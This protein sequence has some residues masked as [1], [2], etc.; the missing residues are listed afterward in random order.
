MS[1]LIVTTV[2]ASGTTLTLND[3][4]TVNG[5]LTATDVNTSSDVALKQDIVTIPDAASIISAMRGVN[6]G[7]KNGGRK[8]IGV[9]AQEVEEILPEIVATDENG[10][11]AVNYAALTGVLI[12][13]VKDLQAQVAKLSK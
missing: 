9:V 3:N 1:T 2:Q 4:T 5:T 8:S 10:L 11:K 7:W 13:A 12:E 6:F